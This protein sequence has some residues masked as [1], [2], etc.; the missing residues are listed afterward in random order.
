[1]MKYLTKVAMVGVVVG[2]SIGVTEKAFAE[3]VRDV[4]KTVTKQIPHT[5]R[6]CETTNV[7][8]YENSMD[9]DGAIVG[10]LI[11]GIIGHQIKKGAGTGVGAIAGSIIGGQGDKKI[12]GYEKINQCYDNTTYTTESKEVYSYSV[13]EFDYEGRPYSIK[14]RK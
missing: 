3:E 9:T 13:V 5:E 14:F 8:I 11:G 1:M 10:G 12:V 4:Y 2:A 7:P 6:V